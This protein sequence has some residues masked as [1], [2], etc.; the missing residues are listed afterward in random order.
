MYSFITIADSS[1]MEVFWYY[2]NLISVVLKC[3]SSIAF[4]L[5]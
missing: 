4:L 1:G 5:P 2:P 3:K